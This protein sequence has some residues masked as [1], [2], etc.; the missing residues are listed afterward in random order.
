MVVEPYYAIPFQRRDVLS[1]TFG[2]NF[3][4]GW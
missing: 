3:W 4:P 2:V 1:G